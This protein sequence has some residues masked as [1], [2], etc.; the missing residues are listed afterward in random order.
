M[1]KKNELD[2]LALPLMLSNVLG[3]VIGLCDQAIMG[4]L[5]MECFAV[6]AIVSGFINSVTGIL[7]MTATRFNILGSKETTSVRVMDDMWAQVVLSIGIGLL[8]I[9]GIVGC[10]PFIFQYIY[11][12]KCTLST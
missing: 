12:L 11:Q 3:L 5:S 10:G 9:L 1:F 6:V 8:S 2:Q 4:H 7:G